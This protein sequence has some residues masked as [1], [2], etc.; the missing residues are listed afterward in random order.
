[1]VVKGGEGEE[2]RLGWREKREKLLFPLSPFHLFF[3]LIYEG[4]EGCYEGVSVERL[5]KFG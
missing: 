1:M 2:R 5:E 4:R 3:T